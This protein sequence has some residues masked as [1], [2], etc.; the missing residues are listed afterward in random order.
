MTTD[1]KNQL[2]I[3]RE[4][5]GKDIE[6]VN[7]ERIEHQT[8][9]KEILNLIQ[10]EPKTAPE[11]AQI[12][13]KTPREIFWHLMALKKYNYVIDDQKKGDYV[14]YRKKN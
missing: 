12:L 14:G 11:I 8:L 2:K 9:H 3:L 5:R 7:N 10:T 13:N 6:R 1:Y 4:L